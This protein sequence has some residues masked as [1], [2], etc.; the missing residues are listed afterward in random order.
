M[1]Q[2]ARIFPPHATTDQIYAQAR[3]QIDSIPKSSFD[4]YSKCHQALQ[5]SKFIALTVSEVSA[6]VFVYLC[7][8][9]KLGSVSTCQ[10]QDDIYNVGNVVTQVSALM[11]AAGPDGN[12]YTADSIQFHRINVFYRHIAIFFG[13]CDISTAAFL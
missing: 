9:F 12:V 10:A 6:N 8:F 4:S 3:I 1:I 7:T 5:I 13:T 2:E 11:E